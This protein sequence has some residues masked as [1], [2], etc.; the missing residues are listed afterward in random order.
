METLG[1]SLA[2]KNEQN[3]QNEYFCESCNY[4]CSKKFNFNRHILSSKHI[5]VTKGDNLVAKSGKKVANIIYCCEKCNKGYTSRN[6][7][8]KH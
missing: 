3:I 2:S 4:K 8:W 5:Q 7:L 6:G 1:D